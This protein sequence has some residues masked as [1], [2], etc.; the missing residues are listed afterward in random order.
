MLPPEGL[1]PRWTGDGQ[2]WALQG[3]VRS[4]DEGEPPRGALGGCYGPTTRLEV[5]TRDGARW[6]LGWSVQDSEGAS[7]PVSPAIAPGAAVTLG[8]WTRDSWGSRAWPVGF[9]LRDDRGPLLVAGAALGADTL[10]VVPEVGEPV[11]PSASR[12]CDESVGLTLQV[13]GRAFRPGEQ[14]PVGD[15][16]FRNVGARRTSRITCTDTLGGDHL[17]WLAWR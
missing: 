15:L 5:E 9:V 2:A 16:T 1:T 8:Y 7:V 4:V 10:P 3:V 17:S 14:G 12:A 13:A 6:T 11:G